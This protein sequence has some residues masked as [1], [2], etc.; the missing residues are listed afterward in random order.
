MNLSIF[1]P[2][3]MPNPSEPMQTAQ[4]MQP[5]GLEDVLLELS[6]RGRP[7]LTITPR[8]AGW[9]C[10]MDVTVTP[11][12]AAFEIKSESD[13]KTPLEA[14]LQCRERLMLAIASLGGQA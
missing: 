13:C 9:W 6:K 12:G 3:A 4:T 7:T 2:K 14:A 5:E 8:R 1:K 11:I 10:Y